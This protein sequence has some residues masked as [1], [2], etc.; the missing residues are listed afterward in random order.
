MLQNSY[1][2]I[3]TLEINNSSFNNNKNLMVQLK[4]SMEGISLNLL[5]NPQG[6]GN[7]QIFFAILRNFQRFSVIY[8][9]FSYAN[10]P[11]NPFQNYDLAI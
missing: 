10:K 9:G 5:I 3:S 8:G 2:L 6:L 1:Y 4:P 11:E 7:F